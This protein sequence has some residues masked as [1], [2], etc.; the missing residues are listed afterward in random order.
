VRT[1]IRIGLAQ[2]RATDSDT[3]IQKRFENEGPTAADSIKNLRRSTLDVSPPLERRVR[4]A[5]SK[6]MP[7]C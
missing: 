5:I 2:V 1:L 3:F 4:L 6:A 7:F